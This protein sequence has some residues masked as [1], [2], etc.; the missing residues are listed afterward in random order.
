MFSVVGENE[1]A[2]FML[3]INLTDLLD[4]TTSE[5]KP[6]VLLES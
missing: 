4:C 5:C 6:T 1:I 2:K 3:K